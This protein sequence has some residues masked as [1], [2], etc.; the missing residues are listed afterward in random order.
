MAIRSLLPTYLLPVL[1]VLASCSSPEP[2]PAPRADD[3]AGA[4][5][6]PEKPWYEPEI[7]AFEEADRL[8]PPGPGG[9]LFVGSSSIRLWPDLEQAMGRPVLQRGF[10]G[11]RTHEVLAVLERIVLPCEPATIVY[12]CGDNDLGT[13]SQDAR[14]AADGFLRFSERV[15]AV[16]PEVRILYLAIKPSLARWSNW[17]AMAEANRLVAE[18]CAGTP[19]VDFVDVAGCLLGPDGTPDPTLF[20]ADGLHLSERGYERWEQVLRPLLDGE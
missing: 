19:G 2:T 15:R 17:P 9:L 6:A 13:H 7:R 1:L 12:Y 8:H 10:G 20:V 18:S 16:L 11:A 4:G 3:P 5:E 14:A